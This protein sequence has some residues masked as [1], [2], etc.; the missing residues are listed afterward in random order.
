MSDKCREDIAEIRN[1]KAPAKPN[2][3]IN[4]IEGGESK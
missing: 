4:S 3:P 2:M 1:A